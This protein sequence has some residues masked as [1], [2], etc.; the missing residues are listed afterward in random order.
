MREW[1]IL[2]VVTMLLG[3]VAAGCE[4]SDPKGG[5]V[6]MDSHTALASADAINVAGAN[7][8]DLVESLAQS[9]QNYH[10]YLRALIN[11]YNAEGFRHKAVWAQREL[12]D[13]RMVKTYRYL[14]EAEIPGADLRPKDS[15]PAADILYEDAYNYAKQGDKILDTHG[16]SGSICIA[17]YEMG[18]DLTWMEKD[19]DYYNS[20]V[21]R[22]KDHTAQGRL[23]EPEVKPEPV[24]L[25][26]Y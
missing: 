25:E 11:Y 1:K 22:Y 5:V 10:Q 23:F 2:A 19:V 15:I 7:E 8:V 24:Q 20:A 14:V 16:G 21:Q 4:S 12:A 18:F 9:R 26:L 13:L 17:C 3:L 6:S